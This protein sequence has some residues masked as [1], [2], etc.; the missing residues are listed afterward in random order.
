MVNLMGLIGHIALDK[1]ISAGAPV[2][3]KSKAVLGLMALAGFFIFLGLGFL[4]F[5]LN[6]WLATIYL[7]HIA[8]A[9]TG[10]VCLFLAVIAIL[11]TYLVVELKKSR[12]QKVQNDMLGMINDVM[13][14][15]DEELAGFIQGN[16]KTALA[17]AALAGVL[18]GK[19]FL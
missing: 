2:S 18:L 14:S 8:T 19:R 7:P 1:F 13:D 5:A 10:G 15:A 17:V 4:L 12:L 6:Q 9:I 3:Q 16:P 11:C